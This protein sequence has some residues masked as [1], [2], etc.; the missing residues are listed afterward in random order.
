MSY[1]NFNVESITTKEPNYNF[2]FL[3]GLGRIGLQFSRFRSKNLQILEHNQVKCCKLLLNDRQAVGFESNHLGFRGTSIKR[4]EWHVS[5]VGGS[6][7]AFEEGGYQAF[8]EVSSNRG[9]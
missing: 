8:G 2:S 3:K 4:G 5:G 9:R 1:Y 6:D 7:Q